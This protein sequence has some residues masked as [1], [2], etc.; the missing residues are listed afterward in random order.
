MKKMVN[1]YPV[2]PV[3]SIRTPIMTTALN[4]ELSYGDILNC[5]YARAIV[6]EVLPNGDTVRLNLNNYNKCNVPQTEEPVKVEEVIE[7]VVEEEVVV[8]P[9]VEEDEV[10]EI[11]EEVTEEEITI[12]EETVIEEEVVVEVQEESTEE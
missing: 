6:D 10:E 4:C 2:I 3:L 7:E 9:V 11:Q 8:E 1:V 12:V 5:I